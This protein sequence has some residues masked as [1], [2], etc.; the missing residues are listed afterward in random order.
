ME[1]KGTTEEKHKQS[2]YA[3]WSFY[4]QNIMEPVRENGF[5]HRQVTLGKP[6]GYTSGPDGAIN[7]CAWESFY[8]IQQLSMVEPEIA[9]DAML[10]FID[11]IPENGKLS[12]ESLPS[13]KAH[14]VWVCYENY[15]DSKPDIKN[16]LV[17]IYPK[18]KAY[19][20]WRADNPR[21]IMGGNDIHDE[22]D[23][24]FITQWYSDV[25]YAIKICNEI[26]KTEDVAMWENMKN[27][28]AKNTE[29]WFF[30]DYEKEGII[31]NWYFTGDQSHYKKYRKKE[32]E[33]VN[34]SVSALNADLPK[35]LMDKVVE[36]Y[37]EKVYQKDEDLLGFDFYKYGD[38]C[39]IAYGLFE[40][41]SLYPDK[42]KGHWKQLNNAILRHV[43]KTGEF[44]EE[45]KPDEYNTS[46]VAPSTFTASAMI[47]FTYMN[48]GI[49]IDEGKPMVFND[50]QT[51]YTLVNDNL[52]FATLKGEGVN[53]PKSIKVA[54]D[55][56][57]YD[58]YVVWDTQNV[59]INEAGEYAITGKVSVSDLTVNATIHVYDGEV[60]YEEIKIQT[61]ENVV[62]T[63]PETLAV[64]Y[65]IHDKTYYGYTLVEWDKINKEDLAL[66]NTLKVN[67]KLKFNNQ[68]IEATIN[69]SDLKI[70]SE[71]GTT[72]VQEGEN[73]TLSVKNSK[74]EK[75]KV[76]SWYIDNSS[77]D[78]K[79]AINNSGKVIGVLP[80]TQ[81]V[82]ARLE[83]GLVLSKE[84]TVEPRNVVSLSYGSKVNAEHGN[85]SAQLAV[86]L[87]DTTM[88]RSANNNDNQSITFTL[89]EKSKVDGIRVLWYKETQ[90]KHFKVKV[91]TDNE[92]WEEVYERTNSLHDKGNNY[93]DSIVFDDVKNA[94]YI[95]IE[96]IKAGS[97]I[98]GIVEFDTYGYIE[99]DKTVTNVSIS[100]G[101]DE[102]IINQKAKTLQLVAQLQP[103]DVKDDRVIWTVND[104]EKS[105]SKVAKISK[106]GIVTPLSNG[107]VKVTATSLTNPKVHDDVIIKIENQDLLNVALNQKVTATT[108]DDNHQ[109]KNAVD[110]KMDTRWGSKA[111]AP[112]D[113]S[114]A[115]H[116][117]KEYD[118]SS[119]QIY[120][121]SAFLHNY[122]IQYSKSEIG[123]DDKDIEWIDLKEI[124]G[125]ESQQ[126]MHVFDKPIKANHMRILSTEKENREWL[127]SIYEFEVYGKYTG[128]NVLVESID[129][130][131]KDNVSTLDQHGQTLQMKAIVKP[132]QALN[133][134]VRWEVYD[135][136]GSPTDKATISDDGLLTAKKNGVVKVVAKAQDGS[137]VCS[138]EFLVEIKNQEFKNIALDKK[139]TANEGSS[140][141]Q[142]PEFVVDGNADRN[143]NKDE[144]S[145]WS[146]GT[147]KNKDAW[148]TV[149][150][151]DYYY[152]N[153]VV[154]DWEDAYGKKYTILGSKDGVNYFELAKEDN[155]QGGITQYPFNTQ[156]L[157]YVKM[158]GIEGN[159]E[160][161][162]SIWEFEIYGKAV[163]KI[164]LQNL[165]N[166]SKQFNMNHYTSATAD[167]LKKAMEESKVVLDRENAKGIDIIKA[168][169]KLK[170]AINQLELKK[171]DYTKV[172]Q[173]IK[174]AQSLNQDKYVDFSLVKKAVN[175]VKYDLDIT[176]QK[177]VDEMAK[178]IEN[179]IA[180]LKEKPVIVVDK[181]ELNALIEKSE[182]LSKDD[183][184]VESWNSLLKILDMAKEISNNKDATQETV[185]KIKNELSNAL[186]SLKENEIIIEQDKPQVDD[187]HQENNSYTQSS[188]SNNTPQT[189]DKYNDILYVSLIGMSW[190]VLYLMMKRKVNR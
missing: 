81:N 65:K 28:M 147:G 22:K 79:I 105:S 59:K 35:E 154:F 4:Y 83:N 146:S 19:L 161:G 14:T 67:G 64:N 106:N 97:F 55:E 123:T 175:A 115:I 21:W 125:N 40:K 74:N 156:L 184:T 153:K 58:A 139:V 179:A 158:Q 124:S 53:L 189:G 166:Q 46:G 117:D 120:F 50:N 157:R 91:S 48:N 151:G 93:S 140:D 43:I 186:E 88:W 100:D 133:K 27:D 54:R 150:L 77:Y 57:Q 7:S 152:V 33:Y 47:D 26:G 73:L 119:A 86:D 61:I 155:G 118:I 52:E 122:K 174:H 84:I 76:Q 143:V 183:Y 75:Q 17:N 132:S 38:G 15:K 41:E 171:A 181:T 110:G 68:D 162:F 111:W 42:L 165:Y 128:E 182:N 45:C 56:V 114:F 180:S 168:M 85:N 89:K 137:Q 92:K 10:G 138:N 8:C 94:K 30:D 6:S 13:Q 135:E 130:G 159:P 95:K 25:N 60:T 5:N 62:P 144:Q 112:I 167:I 66:G 12:G 24:S 3:A 101:K 113:S 170:D 190:L 36:F 39:Q 145:R 141:K 178:A 102:L 87:N 148:I 31:H 63:L 136:D 163:D 32:N 149:D 51:S 82:V 187:D 70:V 29:K 185:D 34:Y 16:E 18:L 134:K 104:E 80:G 49:R 160:Y 142:K 99:N 20:K 169:N 44:G 188:Q 69:V 107:T 90:P 103:N 98:P 108:Q 173:A 129:I 177:E 116:F 121:E 172:N 96:I 9:W 37:L 2:F 164:E 11:S 72:I 176:K 23:I 71:T 78:N 131:S 1:A 126:I 127:C 109:A